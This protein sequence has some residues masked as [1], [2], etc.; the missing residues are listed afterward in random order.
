MRTV[1]LDT[2]GL[3]SNW[4][5]TAQSHAA[6]R[7]IFGDIAAQRTP[8][9]TTTFILLECGNSASRRPYRSAV[10]RFREEME[11]AELLIVP[12]EEDWLKAWAAYARGEAGDAGIVDH[13]SFTIMRRLGIADA[14]TN[15]RHFKA[16]GFN[17]LF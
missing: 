10:A 17:T 13:V 4:D 16:A 14:F 5:S 15:D 12:T 8:V 9:V 7:K 2:A 1:F 6:A 3:I 11:A